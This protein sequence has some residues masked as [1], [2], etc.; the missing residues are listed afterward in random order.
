MKSG[1]QGAVAFALAFAF[2]ALAG[3]ALVPFAEDLAAGESDLP[4]L[5][6][7]E[8]TR[9]GGGP[10]PLAGH[11]RALGGSQHCKG[12]VPGARTSAG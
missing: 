10:V 6:D 7:S 3:G 11:D 1:H 8:V 12:T 9:A 4:R 5:R 2:M